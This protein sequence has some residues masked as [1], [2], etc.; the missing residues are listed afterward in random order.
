MIS[1]KPLWK[2]SVHT[3][4]EAEDAI[5]EMLSRFIGSPASAFFDF[6]AGI[7]RVS[8]YVSK[9]ITTDIREKINKGLEH[10]RD[11]GLQIG[12][13]KTLIGR[14]RKEDWRESWKRHFKPIEVG[15]LLLVKPGWSKKKRRKNQA[16][17]IL[18]PGLSF[19]TGQHPTTS[20]CLREIAR[21]SRFHRS[22]SSLPKNRQSFLDMGTGSGILAISAAKLGY[23][24]VH[25]FDFDPEA[26]R[27]ARANARMNGVLGKIQIVRRNVT[28]LP[29]KPKEKYNF[30]CANLISGLLVSEG[31]HIASQL[32]RGGILVLA[33]ILKTEFP[34][35]QRKYEELGLKLVS[36]KGEK[37]W[38]SGSFCFV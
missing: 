35:V 28:K 18:N 34:M 24:R 23:A 4:L 7:S 2:L 26:I 38:Q 16:V 31:K 5:M 6:E 37:E 33:G 20:F 29:A 30:I 9:K 11:C 14:V 21:N 3:T 22:R 15:S 1:R 17:V 36:T 10:I 13:G 25:A 19:G 8:V 32:H 12:E 27:T